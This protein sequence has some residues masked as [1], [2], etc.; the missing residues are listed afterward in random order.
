MGLKNS[1][2]ETSP[3][4]NPLPFRMVARQWLINV[5]SLEAIAD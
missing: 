1:K 5:T 4:P 2:Q 3:N